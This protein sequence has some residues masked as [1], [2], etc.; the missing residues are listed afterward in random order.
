MPDQIWSPT[1]VREALHRLRLSQREA[2]HLF[3]V[4][5]RAMRY[6]TSGEYLP[7]R[8]MRVLLA[9]LLSGKITRRDCAL[10]LAPR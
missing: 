6:Y 1:D 2:A 4:S 8:S 9:L 3:G 7:S 10:A 5:E